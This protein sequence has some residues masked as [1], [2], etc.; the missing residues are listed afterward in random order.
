MGCRSRNAG[1]GLWGTTVRLVDVTGLDKPKLVADAIP[2]HFDRSPDESLS[3]LVRERIA[4]ESHKPKALPRGG[5]KHDTLVL[6]CRPPL[7]HLG[8]HMPLHPH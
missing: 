3:L 2:S 7:D 6:T 4:A 8:L 1:H 5:H